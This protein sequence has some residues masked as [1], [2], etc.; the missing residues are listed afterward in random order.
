MVAV[1]EVKAT[2]A[3][4]DFTH[5]IGDEWDLQPSKIYIHG[6]T[7]ASNTLMKIDGCSIVA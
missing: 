5:L 1:M 7:V 6:M 3:I 2:H 4:T